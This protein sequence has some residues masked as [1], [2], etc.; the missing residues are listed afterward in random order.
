MIGWIRIVMNK[1]LGVILSVVYVNNVPVMKT[2]EMYLLKIFKLDDI[3]YYILI[4]FY[5]LVL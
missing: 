4:K 2:N 5:L 3:Y 1:L